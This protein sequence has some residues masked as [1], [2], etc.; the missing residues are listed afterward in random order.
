MASLPDESRL[1]G[2]VLSVFASSS[3]D[4]NWPHY[5][6]DAPSPRHR[7]TLSCKG[8]HQEAAL[9][10]LMNNL[11]PAVAERPEEL[12]VYGGGGQ[13]RAQ[14]GL[15]R[16]RSSPRS[17]GWRTT[18]RCWCRAASRSACSAPTT[19]RRGC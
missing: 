12:I 7:T 17:G 11:D 9:R 19:R 2:D 16:A 18:R 13:G 6:H 4:S 10:M 14:L 1:I 8:W 5:H 3:V 15:L